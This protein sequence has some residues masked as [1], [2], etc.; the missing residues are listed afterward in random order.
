MFFV[1]WIWAINF[2]LS[3]NAVTQKVKTYKSQSTSS[4]NAFSNLEPAEHT[5]R[6]KK[7]IVRVR[8]YRLFR[9]SKEYIQYLEFD[10]KRKRVEWHGIDDQLNSTSVDRIDEEN[11][12]GE[13]QTR[14]IRRRIGTW[15]LEHGHVI[16]HLPWRVLDVENNDA[17]F[18]SLHDDTILHY[19]AIIHLQKFS[20]QPRM[21]KGTISRDRSNRMNWLRPVVGTFVARGVGEDTLDLDYSHRAQ[22]NQL[23]MRKIE[24]QQIKKQRAE[25]KKSRAP[26]IALLE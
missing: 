17:D 8:P 11:V 21:F 13:H 23:V 2:F 26:R 5:L 4:N 10:D 24:R 14:S 12:D 18:L 7:W 20:H 15:K 1:W 25:T 9:R 16:W 22:A 19:R 6:T 3:A